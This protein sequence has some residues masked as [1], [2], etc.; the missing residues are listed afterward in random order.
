MARIFASCGIFPCSCSRLYQGSRFSP[1]RRM[2]LAALCAMPFAWSGIPICAFGND[3]G[4]RKRLSAL[5][6]ESGGRLGVAVIDTADGN[7][8]SYRGEERFPL[9]STFKVVAVGAVLKRAA[10]EH[11]LLQR[12]IRFARRDM[13]PW[14][15]VTSQHVAGGMTVAGLCAAALQQSDNTAANLLL[16]LLGGPQ[17]LTDFARSLGDKSFR[18]DRHEP[19]LN[20]SEPGDVRDTTTPAAMATTLRSL[21][22]GSALEPSQRAL[23]WDWLRGNVTGAA[24]IRAGV[25]DGWEVGDKTGSGH[26][27]T[28][29]DVAVLRPPHRAPLVLAL[30]LTQAVG[31]DSAHEKILAESTRAICAV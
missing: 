27:G 8:F 14:S 12:R 29:N 30:Y 26:H 1:G 23:L 21:V 10:V 18:L 24:R 31:D 5:E 13:V 4:V 7:S 2:L 22:L 6:A 19:D 17:T 16:D 25:P 9:C 28:A 15:P 3:R 20:A 11:T